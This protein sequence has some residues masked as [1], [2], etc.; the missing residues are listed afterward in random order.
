VSSEG[1][2][3]VVKLSLIFLSD[4]GHGNDGSVLLMDKSAKGSFSLNEAVGNFQLSAEVREPD[5]KFDGVD[6]VGDDDQFSLF[7][8]NEFGYM[9]QSELEIVRFGI[10]NFLL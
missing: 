1:G 5:N 6:V 3:E 4:L 2:S 10:F 7:L 8:L 9:V